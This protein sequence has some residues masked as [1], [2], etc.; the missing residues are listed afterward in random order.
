LPGLREDYFALLKDQNISYDRAAVTP[1]SIVLFDRYT[2]HLSL[3]ES[4]LGKSGIQE[5]LDT[6]RTRPNDSAAMSGLAAIVRSY[7]SWGFRQELPLDYQTLL[8]ICNTK[9]SRIKL[10][11]ILLPF[12]GRT[13]ATV[14]ASGQQCLVQD[15]SRDAFIK[16]LVFEVLA[17]MESSEESAELIWDFYFPLDSVRDSQLLDEATDYTSVRSNS[18]T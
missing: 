2:P 16:E 4:E 17:Y 1:D 11:R 10:S 15:P 13:T 18:A 9:Q 5:C 12:Y 7:V 14:D 8:T 6:L 3:V